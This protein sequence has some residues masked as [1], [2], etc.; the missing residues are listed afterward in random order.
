MIISIP[1]ADAFRGSWHRALITMPLILRSDH[2]T[3][4]VYHM[5]LTVRT[6]ETQVLEQFHPLIQ[7][8]HLLICHHA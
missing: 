3:A 8:R 1:S 7:L 2:C 4:L 6:L 5:I